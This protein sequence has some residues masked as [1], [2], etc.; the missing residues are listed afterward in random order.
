MCLGSTARGGAD[1]DRDPVVSVTDTTLPALFPLP[2]APG[3]VTI[4][5]A[6]VFGRAQPGDVGR[7]YEVVSATRI[8]GN[9]FHNG[10]CLLTL[11][12]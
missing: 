11:P 8:K 6:A 7:N 5:A 12:R 10:G 1:W 3:G 9:E 2:A 4:R